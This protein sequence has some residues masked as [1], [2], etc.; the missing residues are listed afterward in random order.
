VLDECWDRFAHALRP[1]IDSDRLGVVIASYPSWWSPRPETWAE[2]ALLSQRL[3]GCQIAVEL[4]HPRWFEGDACEGTLEFLEQH[5]L[6]YVCLDGPDQGPRSLSPVVAATADVAVVRFQGRRCVEGEPWT[7]P[8]RYSDDDLRAWVPR[9]ADLASSST[10]V[11]VIMDNCWRADAVDNA[12]R[13][14][15]LVRE[16]DVS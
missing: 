5:G 7:W 4:H 8:Y 6:A 3:P 14:L 12:G 13:L 11:H 10:S 2:L 9:L 1:L 15:E 16:A